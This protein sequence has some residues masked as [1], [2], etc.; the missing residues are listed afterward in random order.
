MVEVY[1]WSSCS[2]A[3]LAAYL[4][5][6]DMIYPTTG[7]AYVE[8]LP[9]AVNDFSVLQIS[10]GLQIRPGSSLGQLHLRRHKD[11]IK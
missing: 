1:M 8:A 9:K 11:E 10:I 6:E 3:Y 4:R 2:R 7:S 5:P